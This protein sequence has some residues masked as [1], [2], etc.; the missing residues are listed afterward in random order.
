VEAV[1][2]H[3]V[4]IDTAIKQTK[5][6]GSNRSNKLLTQLNYFSKKKNVL[7]DAMDRIFIGFFQ[8]VVDEQ[9]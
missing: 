7:I 4:S 5:R 9:M 1:H 6:N 3:A 2:L 8:Y